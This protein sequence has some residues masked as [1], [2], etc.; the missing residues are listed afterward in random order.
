MAIYCNDRK[1]TPLQTNGYDN[2]LLLLMAEIRLTSWYGKYPIICRVLAPSQVVVW[3]FW[4]I[5][6]MEY[7]MGNVNQW[8]SEILNSNGWPV[9]NDDGLGN[10]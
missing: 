1:I 9:V 7:I 8:R 10:P 3:D 6:S 2:P 4:T 5:N